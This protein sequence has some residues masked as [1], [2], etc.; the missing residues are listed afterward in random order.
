[1][2]IH[3][4]KLC[5]LNCLKCYILLSKDQRKQSAS[6]S[7]ASC[8]VVRMRPAFGNIFIAIFD[9]KCL[10]AITIKWPSHFW[11]QMSA[12]GHKRSLTLSAQRSESASYVDEKLRAAKR[13]IQNK[14]SMVKNLIFYKIPVYKALK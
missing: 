3:I 5:I 11:L 10:V 13:I 14:F 12:K 4:L 1:M 8:N 9:F 7:L 2:D 6:S